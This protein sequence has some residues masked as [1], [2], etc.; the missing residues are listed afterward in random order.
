MDTSNKSTT[1]PIFGLNDT[2]QMMYAFGDSRRPNI[3]T[4]KLVETIVLNQLTEIVHQA[5]SVSQKRNFKILNLESI[6][7]LMR[8][9]PLKIQRLVKYLTARDI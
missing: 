5:A 9:S 8:H 2:Q 6:L 1:Q 4:A 3:E 7:Y